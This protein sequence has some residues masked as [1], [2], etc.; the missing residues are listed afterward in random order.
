MRRI[1]LTGGIAS[2]K[3]AVAAM[4]RELGFPVL[5][6]DQLAHRL[7]EPGQP[8]F[9]QVVG[10]FGKAIL[11]P[12]GRIDRARLGT[13]VFADRGKLDRLNAIVHPLVREAMLG[14]FAAWEREGVAGPAFLEAALIVEAGL[15]HDLDGLVV[16]WSTPEQQVARQVAR[17]ASEEEAR[18]RIRMQL[19]VEDKLKYATDRIDASGTLAE[20]RAQ[21]ESLA[22]RL[23]DPASNRER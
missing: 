12:D 6:A 13:I 19:P 8:G 23:R 1:G 18:R 21:V 3:S 20:T 4:L 2:G 9:D 10:E 7:V 16:V 5:D 22:A 15:H 11:A 14:Q 17:G